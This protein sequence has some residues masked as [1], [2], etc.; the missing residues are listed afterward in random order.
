MTGATLFSGIGA[1]EAAMPW[2]DWRYCAEIEKFP[3][4]VHAARHRSPNM[5][6]VMA[7][8][9][10]ERCAA[11]GPIDL[12]VAGSPCQAFSVAGLRGS[13]DDHRGN[14]TMR[15][16]EIIH[17]IKPRYFLWEN[18][19]G[20]LSTHD[21]AF[22]CF[23]GGV[24]GATEAVT[25][26][27]S[28]PRAGV[29]DGPLARGSWRVLDAQYYG[30]AQR[31]KRVFALFSFGDGPPHPAEILLEWEGMRLDSPP[32]RE[33]RQEVTGTL[34][35]RTKSGGGFG[36]DF[37]CA[38]GVV[39][40]SLNAKGGSGRI[41]GESETFIAAPIRTRPYAVNA[42]HPMFTTAVRRLT[43][44]ECERLMGFPDGFTAIPGAADGPRCRALGNSM[45]VP[46]LAWIAE[47]I[48]EVKS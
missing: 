31:R 39:A 15:L 7:R 40:H 24:V 21:N 28:W 14:L 33:T 18:V 2:V 32:S 48:R 23:L 26:G 13:L 46:V 19:P 22:G 10:I 47:R 17:A 30:L 27:G 25:C 38:R 11:F 29:V 37:E 20:V 36:G 8:D 35:A 1:P 45:A 12:L 43:V 16:V 34:S 42:S 5:G 41:D 4:A 9:F 44:T 3:S 6:D